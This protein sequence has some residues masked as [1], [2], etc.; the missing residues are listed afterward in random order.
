M[1]G[2][3]QEESVLQRCVP[4]VDARSLLA[5][6]QRVVIDLRSPEE[7][8]EDQVPGSLNVPLF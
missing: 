1:S 7:F 3:D 4:G 8:R 6:H 2:S 5:L